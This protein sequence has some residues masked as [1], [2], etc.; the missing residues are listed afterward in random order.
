MTCA[1]WSRAIYY[2]SVW[3]SMTVNDQS[4]SRSRWNFAGKFYEVTNETLFAPLNC[5]PGV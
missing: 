2:R 4:M 1:A 3:S 5:E